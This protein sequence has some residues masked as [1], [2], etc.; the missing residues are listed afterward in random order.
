MRLDRASPQIARQLCGLVAPHHPVVASLLAGLDRRD[1]SLRHVVASLDGLRWVGRGGMESYE[2]VILTRTGNCLALSSL[3]SATLCAAGIGPAYVLVAG[4][5]SLGKSLVVVADTPGLLTAHAW[6]IVVRPSGLPAIVDPV[7]MLIEDLDGP[8]ALRDRVRR[9][10]TE[11]GLWSC[12][13]DHRVAHLF[14]S[15]TACFQVLQDSALRCRPATRDV[16]TER[17]A[18]SSRGANIE[19]PHEVAGVF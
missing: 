13:F 7:T 19:R 12:L 2:D 9:A 14:R 15:F 6:T 10:A 11:D 4:G 3:L 17:T 5:G 16:D 1:L 18:N 8:E